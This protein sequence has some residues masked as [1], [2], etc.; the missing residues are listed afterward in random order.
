MSPL[1]QVLNCQDLNAFHVFFFPFLQIPWSCTWQLCLN[2]YT[3]KY[4]NIWKDKHKWWKTLAAFQDKNLKYIQKITIKYHKVISNAMYMCAVRDIIKLVIFASYQWHLDWRSNDWS[5]RGPDC[6]AS[7][8]WH[9]Q[10]NM[11]NVTVSIPLDETEQK[12]E[13]WTAWIKKNK[14]IHDFNIHNNY[15]CW[16]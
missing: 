10:E 3:Q 12:E 16:N 2:T 7:L 11:F 9:K 1:E 4:K 14:K 13:N 15:C 6:I 5:K 8:W